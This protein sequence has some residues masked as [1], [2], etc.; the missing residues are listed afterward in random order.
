MQIITKE[1]RA[2]ARALGLCTRCGSPLPEG[3][4]YLRC[5]RCLNSQQGANAT[6]RRTRWN[7]RAASLCI[8]CGAP[9]G[10]HYQCQPC[11]DQYNAYQREHRRQ[12]PERKW[13]E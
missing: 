4:P 5:D 6:R 7:R 12:I 3:H 8:R 11:A 2:L 9:S 10:E 1:E 13:R